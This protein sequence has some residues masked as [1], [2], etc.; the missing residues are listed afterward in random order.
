MA[1]NTPT[2]KEIKR[3]FPHTI[4]T[5]IQ[6]DPT[7]DKLYEV[8]KLFMENAA[9]IETLYE[10]GNHGHLGLIINPDRYLQEAGQC[11]VTPPRPPTTP[12]LPRQFMSKVEMAAIHQDHKAAIT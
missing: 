8:Q 9:F 3:S 10:G 6:G 4:I 11:F 1:S 12:T 5:K 7:Y 2:V